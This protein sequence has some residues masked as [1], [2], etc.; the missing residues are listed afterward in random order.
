MQK[1]YGLIIDA[2]DGSGHLTWFRD[3]RLVHQMLNSDKQEL[4]MNEGQV[5]QTLTLPDDLDLEAT[6]FRFADNYGWFD[7]NA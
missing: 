7:F 3:E 6:G 1:I 5:D 2:G 4:W